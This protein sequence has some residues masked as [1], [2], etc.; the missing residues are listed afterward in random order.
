[1]ALKTSLVKWMLDEEPLPISR[2]LVLVGV[3]AAA[4]AFLALG[5]N[6]VRLLLLTPQEAEESVIV[7]TPTEVAIQFNAQTDVTVDTVDTVDTSVAA[8]AGNADTK[9][10]F[11]EQQTARLS[12]QD[13]L[14]D[15]K[16]AQ[17][18]T[19]VLE[20]SS[21]RTCE[22]SLLAFLSRTDMDAGEI[23]QFRER[24]FESCYWR[25]ELVVSGFDQTETSACEIVEDGVDL[26]DQA[27]EVSRCTLQEP[28]GLFTMARGMEGRTTSLRVKLNTRQDEEVNHLR[29]LADLIL[30]LHLEQ[31]RVMP[32]NLLTAILA[33]EDFKDTSSG[34]P[35]KFSREFGEVP[36]YNFTMTFPDTVLT[37]LSPS[38]FRPREN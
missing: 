37:E 18:L 7:D 13:I 21:S 11:P 5:L 23:S 20:Q 33:G 35:Y 30:D 2:K 27:T 10:F 29:I 38:E 24:G 16:Q 8:D 36:R 25:A 32:L 34:I 3:F 6:T 26:G 15:E 4:L 22:R 31:N 1:M 14:I 28:P 17:P 19:K 9:L 12:A